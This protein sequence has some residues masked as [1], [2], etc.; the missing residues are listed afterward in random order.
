MNSRH[1]KRFTPIIKEVD[2]HFE[3][4]L[5]GDWKMQIAMWSFYDYMSSMDKNLEV[6]G[7][8]FGSWEEFTEELLEL[9]YN[10]LEKL[11]VYIQQF[12]EEQMKEY[13]FK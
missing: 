10:F 4:Y 9:E 11:N 8:N 2:S 7:L 6:H 3:C 1:I 12:D 5:D 13:V